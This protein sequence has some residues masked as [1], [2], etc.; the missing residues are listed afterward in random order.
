[1]LILCL[2][3]KSSLSKYMYHV[4]SQVSFMFLDMLLLSCGYCINLSC[5]LSM[6]KFHRK[7]KLRCFISTLCFINEF[8]S[9]LLLR[10]YSLYQNG[11]RYI[12]NLALYH[13]LI[14]LPPFYSLLII[15]VSLFASI[16]ALLCIIIIYT[17]LHKTVEPGLPS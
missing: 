9:P 13:L 7:K 16:H 1:M 10:S 17:V 8:L 4:N 15:M 3:L 5:A 6:Q 11:N 2:Y 14:F 12:T